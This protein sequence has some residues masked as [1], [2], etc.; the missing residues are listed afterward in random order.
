MAR[1][2]QNEFEERSPHGFVVLDPDCCS[3]ITG[4]VAVANLVRA[5]RD[6]V[7]VTSAQDR[8]HP[9]EQP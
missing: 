7:A 2:L 9:A 3:L 8:T 5:S 4:G 6:W 1:A